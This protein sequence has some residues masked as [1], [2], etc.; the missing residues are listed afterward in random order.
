MLSHR[1]RSQLDLV[2]INLWGE[3]EYQYHL[4]LKTCKQ[5]FLEML[6]K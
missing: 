3:L 4:K 5:A 6:E 1:V 2:S